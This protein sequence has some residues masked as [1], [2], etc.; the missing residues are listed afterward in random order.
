MTDLRRSLI[1]FSSTLTGLIAVVGIMS[2]F[3]IWSM[4]RAY[5]EGG[6]EIE[7]I[8][9]LA[10]EGLLTQIDFKVQ[11]QEWKNILLRG[12]DKSA[13]SKYLAAFQR[14]EGGVEKH[15][16]NI[17]SKAEDIGLNDYSNRAKELIEQHRKLAIS[18]REALA[19]VPNLTPD[20]ARNVDRLVMGIDRDLETKISTLSR[21]LS[22]FS[23]TRSESLLKQLAT[24]YKTLRTVLLIIICFSLVVTLLSLYGALRSARG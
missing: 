19:S 21:N 7:K 14:R 6:L 10:D 23:K 16:T 12:S 15:L 3:S 2:L 11:V 20:Q 5:I 13:R 9:N 8:H 17:V 18:Y 4:N 22:A 24:R 1:R